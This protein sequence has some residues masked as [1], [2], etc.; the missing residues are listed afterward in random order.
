M[1]NKTE[2]MLLE[3]ALGDEHVLSVYI[4]GMEADPAERAKWRLDLAHSL[5]RIRSGLGDA[6]RAE[7][8][9]FDQCADSLARELSTL[10]GSVGAPGWMAFITAAGLQHAEALPVQEPTMAVWTKGPAVAPYIK[11]LK[12]QLPVV[13]VLAD[14][15]KGRIH[16]YRAGD[17]AAVKS[18]H[19]RA[20]AGNHPHMSAPPGQ[21]FHQGTG[22]GPA[23]DSAQKSLLT[24]V[25]RMVAELSDQAV[26]LA[27]PEG[28]I[29]IGGIPRVAAR[30]RTLLEAAAPGRVVVLDWL[31]IHSS[32]ADLA[33]AAREGA[34]VL[35]DA[36]D[37]AR[38]REIEDA[39]HGAMLGSLGPVA[40]REAL[41][42]HRVRELYLTPRYA[43]DHSTDAEEAVRLALDQGAMVE[44]V[45]R[46][47]A[48]RLDR[49]G[50]IS[51]RL[52]YPL[53]AR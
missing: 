2:L 42:A 15:R 4:D 31:D 13:L 7:R 11:V 27:G 1:L 5:Q 28:W 35:R 10:P 20:H 33:A 39:A 17:L 12:E 8:V 6:S 49:L 40:T 3:R 21:G 24:G 44:E 46:A 18:A 36:E 14:A 53:R 37:L 47:A 52:R 38:I 22:G 34:S 25:Q 45:S 32:P 51:A 9:E 43:E 50:G 26:A 29:V 19:A 23:R 41:R 30:L 48:E 16:L